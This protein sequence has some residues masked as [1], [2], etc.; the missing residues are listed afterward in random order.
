[1]ADLTA[2]KKA[3]DPR[4]TKIRQHRLQHEINSMKVSVQKFE[5]D[6][7]EAEVNIDRLHESIEA[8][9]GRIVIKEAELAKAN[10]PQQE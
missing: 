2:G 4:Q 7:L 6:I 10:S 9:N 5:I 1:M 8:T 3:V